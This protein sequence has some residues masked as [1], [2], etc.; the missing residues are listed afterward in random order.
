MIGRHRRLHIVGV[1][2][3][4]F[5][6]LLLFAV[7]LFQY[8][9]KVPIAAMK[10]GWRV[11]FDGVY[12]D[13]LELKQLA[14]VIPHKLHHGDKI[15]TEY[16]LNF[17]D[18]YESP[19]LF[20]DV[21]YF[22]IC[23][24]VDN[25]LL[26]AYSMEDFRKHRFVGKNYYYISIPE[27]Y[28]GKKLTIDYYYTEKNGVVKLEPPLFGDFLDLQFSFFHKNW[29][30]LVCG[31]FLCMFGIYFF[32]TSLLFSVLIPEVFGQV[33]SAVISLNLGIWTLS[34]FRLL[35]L[36]FNIQYVTLIDYITYF[37][38]SPLFF[39]LIAQIHKVYNKKLFWT[40][41]G[42]SMLISFSLIAL[43]FLNIAHITEYRF[44]Y[45][46]TGI[47]LALVLVGY[48]IDDI[49]RHNVSIVTVLQM[50]GPTLFCLCGT[51][52]LVF[53][54]LYGFWDNAAPPNVSLFI[55]TAG[56]MLF[57]LTRF[58]I[59]LLL[60]L[61]SRPRRLEFKSLT[62]LAYIDALTGLSNRTFYSELAESLKNSKN[63]YCIVSF[64]L[65]NLKFVNDTF[66]HSAGDKLIRN[67]AKIIKTSFPSN[68]H[69]CRVGGDEFAVVI[70]DVTENR[71]DMSLK[72]ICSSLSSLNKREPNIEH[73]VA[74]GYAFRHEQTD[75]TPHTIYLLADKRM[76]DCK[77]RYKMRK[78]N[79]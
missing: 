71:V 48:D 41:V 53:Y 45:Y 19:T 74:Y 26:E 69:C 60:L 8:T 34:T 42:M 55:F 63:D 11:A 24:Y 73:S 15:T 20:L 28:H 72:K 68:A 58:M 65:N 13:D 44:A 1:T 35:P 40:V 31:I 3:F 2:V 43:H 38:I 18:Y 39:L 76:Y 62:R 50:T 67:C 51:I 79:A 17:E 30:P 7:I 6:A 22:A 75:G 49:R 66:G 47:I 33:I 16:I 5:V 52:A 27:N 10:T 25:E 4:A 14:K 23:V 78:T 77:Q 64:D 37:M 61:E 70:E 46:L 54:L 56:N 36:F 57:V 59:Y 12:Y 9:P 21:H 32:F 29:F